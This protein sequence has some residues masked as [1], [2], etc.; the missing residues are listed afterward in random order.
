VDICA[1]P[2]KPYELDSD[3]SVDEEEDDEVTEIEETVFEAN[4]G[5][6]RKKRS[7]NY[8]ELEDA[9]L[10]R[11]W[12]RVGLDAV[13][14]TNQTGKRYWQRIE[15]QYC[16]LKPP[17]STLGERTYRSLQGRWDFIN[18]ACSRWTAALDQVRSQPPS[19]MVESDYVSDLEQK[20]GLCLVWFMP[21]FD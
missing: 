17:S 5:E 16:K 4:Q 19:S 21:W 1:P 12:S 3:D 20:F 18:P 6:G 14:S 15:D 9:M 7:S 13:T 2:L 8:T 11:A 10:V